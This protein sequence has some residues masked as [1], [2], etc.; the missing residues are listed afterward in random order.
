MAAPAK[1]PLM[2][3]SLNEWVRVFRIAPTREARTRKL[4][5]LIGHR[6]L[7]PA[8]LQRRALLVTRLNDAA[9]WPQR[10]RRTPDG[11]LDAPA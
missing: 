9:L 4:N 8:V 10:E 11:A 5:Q 3:R 6:S 7:D 1:D 2:A